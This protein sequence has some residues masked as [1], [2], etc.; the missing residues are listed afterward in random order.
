MK[1]FFERDLLNS[2][3]SAIIIVQGSNCLQLSLSHD[4]LDDAASQF[5]DIAHE[6]VVFFGFCSARVGL[7]DINAN[8]LE[9][10]II[11]FAHGNHSGV[12]TSRHTVSRVMILGF[13]QQLMRE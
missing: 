13:F 11:Y 5:P 2:I 10:R 6:T 9:M 3:S 12:S 7:L 8:A 1:C 4:I